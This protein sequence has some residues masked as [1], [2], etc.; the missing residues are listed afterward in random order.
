[1][2]HYTLNGSVPQHLYGYVAREI[3]Y[4]LDSSKVGQFEPCVLFGITS[5]PSR[6]IHFSIMCESGAQFARI[7]IHMLRWIYPEREPRPLIDLQCWDSYGWSFSVVQYEY[8]REMSCDYRT[9][10]GEMVPAWYWFTLDHTDNSYS[11]APEQHKCY[12]L[13]RLEDGTGQIA[14][15]PNNR[16]LWRDKSFVRA[17]HPLDYKVMHSSTWHSEG[18]TYNP[19]DTAHTQDVV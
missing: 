12:H 9:P 7:P 16:I 10:S 17:G 19:Q 5:I 18:T 14:A 1:M 4:G 13:L 8:L 15:M 6:A 11:N 2:T 3:L